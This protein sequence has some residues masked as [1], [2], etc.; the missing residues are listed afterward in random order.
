MGQRGALPKTTLQVVR[1]GNPGHRSKAQIN[2]ATRKQSLNDKSI[3]FKEPVWPKDVAARSRHLWRTLLP[4]LQ[5]TLDMNGAQQESL[6][7][8][9]IAQAQL[10]LYN[11]RVSEE[12]PVVVG[13]RGTEVRHPL[14]VVINTLHSQLKV[15]RG[16]LGLSPGASI[17]MAIPPKEDSGGQEDP[18]D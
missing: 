11:H 5:R 2:A 8:Y 14:W 15:L 10:E 7:N 17:R 4:V 12:G 16:E 6:A 13:P 9:C 3:P 18:F 1:D